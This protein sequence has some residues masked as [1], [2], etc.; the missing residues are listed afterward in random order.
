MIK[1]TADLV[2]LPV[3]TVVRDTRGVVFLR[4]ASIVASVHWKG[5]DGAIADSARLLD[6]DRTIEV[7]WRP[8]EQYDQRSYDAGH[9]AG[10][11]SGYDAGY[12]AGYDVNLV[13][14]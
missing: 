6:E 4:V 1:N 2:A 14:E 9:D 10:Y 8:D 5:T 12:N 13:E 11:D 3:G 7:L